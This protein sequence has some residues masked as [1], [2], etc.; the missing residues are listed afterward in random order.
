MFQ[1]SVNLR[2]LKRVFE[3]Y[4]DTNFSKETLY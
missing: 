3:K 4:V 1:P 2:I